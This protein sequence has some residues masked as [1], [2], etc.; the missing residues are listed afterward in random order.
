M[1]IFKHHVWLV[2]WDLATTGS[3]HFEK[4][5]QEILCG[6]FLDSVQ[7]QIGSDRN[8]LKGVGKY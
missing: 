5:R 7:R 4:C 6:S 1:L 3:C 2:L 8:E